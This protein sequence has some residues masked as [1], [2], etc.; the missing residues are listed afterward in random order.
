[1]I[2]KNLQQYKN[3]LVSSRASQPTFSRGDPNSRKNEVEEEEV[4]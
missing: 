1:L 4:P 3:D 2:N